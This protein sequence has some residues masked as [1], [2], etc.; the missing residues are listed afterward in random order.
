MKTL[1][2]IAQ[3]GLRSAERSLSVTS[4]NIIN[5]ET[6]GYTRQRVDKSPAGMDM[7]GYHAGL[8]VNITSVT[9]LRNEMNDVLL[10]EKR[11]DF[12]YLQEKAKV[13]A[14]LE[15]SVASD[16]GNDLD[17]RIGRLFDAFSELSANPQD[18]SVRNNL[19]SA[20]EQLTFKMADISR[21]IERTSALVRGSAVKTVDTV[22]GIL[23]DLATLN[24]SIS[25]SN[26]KGQPDFTSLDLRVK[27]L[28]E[29]SALVDFDS[30]L[31]ET[32]SLELRIGG[33]KVLSEDQASVIRPETN[34]VDKTFRL[35]LGSGKT[36]QVSGGKLGAEIDMYEND[37]PDMRERLD[38][39]ASTIVEEF[40]AIHTQGYGLEDATVRNFFDP[41]SKSAAEIRINPAIKN[42]HR[43]IAASDTAGVAGDGD[44]AAAI[45]DLRNQQLIDERKLVD[46]SIDF[47]STPGSHLQE[48]NAEMEVRDSEIQMLTVQQEREAG[49][50]IDEELSLMIR[51][52]NAYQGA[53]RVMSAAQQMYD[54]LISIV[55]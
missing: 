5:A 28:E 49:V 18:M 40:N 14:N 36:I 7:N 26:A 4:N 15:A 3:S 42:N 22:N 2:E 51:Y 8:G 38:Q 10:N 27:K 20:A 34:D 33:I 24:Q 12:G 45:S 32:G 16:T 50:N 53:A 35:R 19:V 54:T 37:I 43:H 47:I 11:Q 30:Q 13:Y 17:F 41:S 23:K 6:P 44:I 29:L 52:Q 39:I 31:T 21:N 25:Q 55:R 46:Y 9:R 48:L 1:F